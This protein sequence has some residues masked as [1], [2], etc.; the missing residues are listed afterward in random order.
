MK[1]LVISSTFP[2]RVGG[3]ENYIYQLCAHLPQGEVV[4]LTPDRQGDWER[5]D[6][7]SLAEQ[8]LKT[9]RCAPDGLH[10]FLRKRRER[11]GWARYLARLCRQEQVGVIHCATA[12]PDGL[13]GLFIQR[14][15]GLPYV[16]YTFGLEI[17]RHQD[18]SWAG[19][20][21]LL[22]LK[23]ASRVVTISE[24]TKQQVVKLGIP[25][26]RVPLV[27]PAVETDTFYP[28]P[29]AGLAVRQRY[30]LVGKKVLLTVGRLVARKGHDKVIEA[31]PAI[32]RQVSDVTYLVTS[33]GPERERLEELVQG[34]GLERHVIFA[35]SV[36]QSELLS[37]YNAADVF[38][39]ASRQIGSDVEGFGIVFLEANACGV[40]VI[41]GRSGGVVDAVSD[42]ESGFL[43]DPN[44]PADIAQQAVTL[45]QDTELARQLGKQGLDRA[46][47]QFTWINA[48]A[49]VQAINEEL[50]PGPPRHSL[51]QA[52]R[53]LMQRQWASTDAG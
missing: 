31:L 23:E 13:T 38:I 15:L 22:G 3:R 42:G 47:T 44:D 19:E 41:G 2:P 27:P 26:E 4:V 45:L 12:L 40:P 10:W 39:M 30:G 25:S 28:D 20:R 24:F 7:Q 11:V 5:F 43:V 33:D 9:I 48:A 37:Y 14:T 34:L 46:H 16:L 35:G 8:G 36:P 50:R 32:L 17:T 49:H 18:E 51:V 21:M 1:S 29:D 52:A 6:T 53:F